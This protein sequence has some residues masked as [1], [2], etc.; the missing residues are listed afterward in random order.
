MNYLNL[1]DMDAYKQSFDLSNQIWKLVMNWD[2]LAQWTV[3][4]QLTS[5]AD[6]NPAKSLKG[7]AVF[8]KR[9][10]SSFFDTVLVPSR[11][12]KIG[13]KW[14]MSGDLLKKVPSNF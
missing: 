11:K 1:K 6:S 13:L 5:S 2:K 4:K 9:K 14:H 7:G 10:R 8:T 3:G 12:H